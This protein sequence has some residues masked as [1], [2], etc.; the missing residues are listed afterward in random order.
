VQHQLEVA[1]GIWHPQLYVDPSTLPT[2]GQIHRAI[3]GEQFDAEQYDKER[4]ERYS[5]RVGFY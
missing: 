5:R 3:H 1:R 2:D 4:T